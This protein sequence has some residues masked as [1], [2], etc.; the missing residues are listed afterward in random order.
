MFPQTSTH[1]YP[2]QV[3]HLYL[4]KIH[5]LVKNYCQLPLKLKD[6]LSL[7]T[8]PQYVIIT[9]TCTCTRTCTCT[10]IAVVIYV[11]VIMYLG[12]R[13]TEGQVGD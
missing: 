7:H 6:Y 8:S 5:L 1:R 12:I 13:V 9:C 2:L 4:V 10:C 11:Y 3:N